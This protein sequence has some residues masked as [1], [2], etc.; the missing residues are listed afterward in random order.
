MEIDLISVFRRITL[1]LVI[2]IVLFIP[3]I[4][5]CQSYGLGFNGQ[6]SSKDIRTGIDLSPNDFF[7]FNEE[8]ELS[9]KML[10]RPNVKMY[11][12]YITRI[13]DKNGKN[14]DLIFNYRSIDSS[15]I[16]I[17]CG[18]KLTRI[19]FNADIR[20]LCVKW[21]EFRLKVDLNKCKV[22]LS[23]PTYDFQEEY[24]GTNLIGDVKI[25]FGNSL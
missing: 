15:S 16:E 20:K 18:Q 21:T 6:E 3:E 23:S 2:G 24:I 22:I 13:I 25:L 17:V 9:F 12:G 8:F 1:L 14:I 7:S 11:F 10:L 5:L 19:S 4:S